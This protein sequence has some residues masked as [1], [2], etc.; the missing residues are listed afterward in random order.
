[1]MRNLILTTC[2]LWSGK[3]ATEAGGSLTDTVSALYEKGRPRRRVVG[4]P[5]DETVVAERMGRV[6]RGGEDSTKFNSM[7]S[8]DARERL[9]RVSGVDVVI[10]NIG[11]KTQLFKNVNN[12]STDT[13]VES[14]DADFIKFYETQSTEKSMEFCMKMIASRKENRL[15]DIFE[16]ALRCELD[17]YQEGL[18][19]Y[20]C[21]GACR[22][23]LNLTVNILSAYG[24]MFPGKFCESLPSRAKV[25]REWR[26]VSTDKAHAFDKYKDSLWVA[27]KESEAKG[28]ESLTEHPLWTKGNKDT[29]IPALK[30][31]LKLMTNFVQ[32][33]TGSLA[34]D[35]EGAR[36]SDIFLLKCGTK[37]AD[38]LQEY[39]TDS[40]LGEFGEI[41][42]LKFMKRY[43]TFLHTSKTGG[44]KQTQNTNQQIL[45]NV[46]EG[47][48]EKP[49]VGK[50]S[51]YDGEHYC[52]YPCDMETIY[53]AHH[54][55]W[56]SLEHFFPDGDDGRNIKSWLKEYTYEKQEQAFKAYQALISPG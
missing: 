55:I 46:L 13:V 45:Y 28:Y 9:A 26:D 2:L 33:A 20:L 35:L 17:Y 16:K 32:K 52:W 19:H 12:L 11:E 15:I 53:N 41:T 49:T 10:Q 34:K 22:S 47:A 7:M 36:E 4:A 30:G 23:S 56:M 44:A 18:E 29:E 21:K 37:L 5:P 14:I 39:H 50:K 1:M 27:I 42:A 8:P 43:T 3:A 24:D 51:E 48:A 6:R 25:L 40:K 31:T 38:V 54:A